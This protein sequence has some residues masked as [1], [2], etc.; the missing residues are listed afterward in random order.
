[1]PANNKKIYLIIEELVDDKTLGVYSE[2]LC[3]YENEGEAFQEAKE[4]N[5]RKPY[6]KFRVMEVPMCNKERL[7][8]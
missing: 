1:M 4:K 5:R 2:I 8:E 6:I 3:A 7:E